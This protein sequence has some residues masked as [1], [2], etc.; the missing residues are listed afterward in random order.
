M[1]A[2][3]PAIDCHQLRRTFGDVTA[4]DEADLKVEAGMQV[5]IQGVSGSGKS[6][7]LNLLGLMDHPTSGSYNLFGHDVAQLTSKEQAQVRSRIF[8]FV[9]Q[10]FNL[11]AD[12]TVA[13]NI[14]TGLLYSGIHRRHWHARIG[15]AVEMVGL[16]HRL[17]ARASTLSG[18][19]QQR[20]AIARAV[21]AD[22]RVVL[23]DEPTGNLD[24]DNRTMVLELLD[25]LQTDGI[26]IITVTH[27]PAVAR[28]SEYQLEM[29]N[30]VLRIA[31]A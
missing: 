21:V 25:R 8:G 27:D 5:S 24:A 10:A 23:C 2:D 22:P 4:V 7:L 15:H 6:T 16:D 26:T 14:A 13:D 17:H 28:R 29:V 3:P 19:E 12:R 1:T 9:F 20:V 11:V 30:G 31:E 18:G